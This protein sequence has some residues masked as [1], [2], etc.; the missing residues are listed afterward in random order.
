MKRGFLDRSK[1]SAR[2]RRLRLS[3]L[4]RPRLNLGPLA[5][6]VGSGRRL[7]ARIVVIT[8][9]VVSVCGIP[10]LAGA[11]GQTT[12]RPN[13]LFPGNAPPGAVPLGAVP[14][15]QELQLGVVLPPSNTGQL[16]SL[17]QDLY[18]PHSPEYHQWL[19]PGEFLQRFGPSAADVSSVESWLDGAGLSATQ[20]G[21]ALNVSA[22]ASRID[23]VLG[24]SLERYRTPSG[25]TG[26]LAQQTPLVPSTLANG[27]I[28]SI[29]GLNTVAQFEPQNTL[30]PQTLSGSQAAVQPLVDGLTPCAAAESAAAPGYYTL[31][32]LGAAYGIGS[33]L[34]DHQNG[35]GETV[36]LY[37]LASHSTSDVSTYE[38]CFGLTNPVSTVAVDGGG[39]PTGGDGTLEADVDIEQVATQ[40]PGARIISYEGPNDTAS[41]AYDTWHAIVSADAAQVVS[42]SWGLCEPMSATAGYISSF[43]PLFEE[44]A[45]QGQTILSAAGDS[46]S[47]DCYSS[48]DNSTA[49]EVDYPSSDPNVTAVGGTSLLGPGDE[50]VW[51]SASG[52]GGGGISRYVAD[53]SWQPVDLSWTST[54]NPCGETCREVPDVSAD[55]GSGHG[56]GG[57]RRVDG[58]RRD[59][60]GRS[61]GGGARGRPKRGLCHRDR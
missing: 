3:V 15:S 52:A 54:G 49:L 43:A 42:T 37:E 34:A 58:G 24:T 2:T 28:T 48:S 27:T 55:R 50:V 26:Y 13:T 44:A 8:V 25:R 45:A 18:D 6:P 59:E 35:Q 33:L 56:R 11:A 36:G 20:S 57:Q 32:A 10:A 53:P 39:G 16:Q 14:S 51:N 7:V 38:S 41:G 31:D 17:L 22:P 40:A 9:L 30:T 23:S 47:E 29:L 21:F 1:A 19:R 60:P 4:E 46:G 61:Y 12:V 5:D